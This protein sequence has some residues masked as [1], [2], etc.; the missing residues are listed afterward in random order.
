MIIEQTCFEINVLLR[1]GE[2]KLLFHLLEKKVKERAWEEIRN[3]EN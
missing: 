3:G 1:I 2:V